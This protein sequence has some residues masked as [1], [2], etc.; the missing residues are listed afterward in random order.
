MSVGSVAWG[1]GLSLAS[2]SLALSASILLTLL[3]IHVVHQRSEPLVAD[4]A[5][6]FDLVYEDDVWL[7]ANKP[8]FVRTAPRHRFE[9]NSMVNRA[10]G[11]VRGKSGVQDGPPQ[12]NPRVLHRLDMDTSGV[13]LYSKDRDVAAHV[14][15]LF[16][17]V[18]AG[19]DDHLFFC[20]F[21]NPRSRWPPHPGRGK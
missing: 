21:S 2:P 10:I 15:G 6:D 14:Q 3:G 9:G 8:P 11:Y 5:G 17:C 16:R 1:T 12:E 19:D 7:C 20:N 13:L 18:R 4:D